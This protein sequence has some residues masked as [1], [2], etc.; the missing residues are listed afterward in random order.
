MDANYVL[1]GVLMNFSCLHRNQFD[2]WIH[3]RIGSTTEN[4]FPFWKWIVQLSHSE[5]QNCIAI[6]FSLLGMHFN[7]TRKIETEYSARNKLADEIKLF[8]MPS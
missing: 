8:G 7:D 3:Y 4:K 1:F 5:R 2:Y 6:L